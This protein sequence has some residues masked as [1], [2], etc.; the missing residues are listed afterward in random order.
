MILHLLSDPDFDLLIMNQME[1]CFPDENIFML[2]SDSQPLSIHNPTYKR[3]IIHQEEFPSIDFSII[4]GIIIHYVS[5]KAAKTIQDIPKN[6]PIACS[7]WGG[8]FYNFLP[9]FKYKL[10]GDLTRKY[11]NQLRTLPLLYYILKDRIIFPYSSDYK[12]WKKVAERVKIF[13]TIIPYEKSLVERYFQNH[14][15]YLPLPTNSLEKGI[16]TDNYEK[17]IIT[18]GKV[19]KNILIGNSGNPTNNHLEALHFVSR[20]K[21]EDISVHLPLTYGNK[22]Y[23]NNICKTGKSLLGSKFYPLLNH[24]T[25]TEYYNF[26]NSFNIFI[27]NNYRQQGIG[28]IINALWCGGKVYLSNRNVTSSYYKDQGLRIFFIEDDLFT[29]TAFNLFIPLTKKEILS[30]RKILIKLYSRES[31]NRSIKIFISSLKNAG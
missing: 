19:R 13:S 26:L 4:D 10:Y 11:L 22:E 8:D 23:I 7:I 29:S 3:I 20:H 28:T 1:E 6:I 24:L 9:E 5:V 21:D 31:V 15:K 2:L 16:N 30:N 27:F 12:I 18:K 14:A 25:Q 17:T